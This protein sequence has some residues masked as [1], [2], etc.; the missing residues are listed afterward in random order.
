MLKKKFTPKCMFLNNIPA[1][2]GSSHFP[3]TDWRFNEYPNPSAHALYVTCV[4]LMSLPLAPNFVGNTL[5][6]VITKGFVV[7]PP[8][9]I[10]LWIN[11]IGLIMAALPDPYWTVLH[12]RILELITNN[13]M[14]EWPYPH[15]PFQL[16]NL[17]TTN[18]AMLENK[19]S[20]TL[21]LAHAIWYHAGAGQIMQVPQ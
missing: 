17:T 9:K 20:L 10:Q 2:T 15:T 13:E 1:M 19:Y 7:I 16:F 3:N 11:A 12:D 4:E 21:A 6:D 8:T 18:D 5:L 14:T